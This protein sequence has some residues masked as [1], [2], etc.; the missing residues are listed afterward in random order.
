MIPCK[1]SLHLG[2]RGYQRSQTVDNVPLTDLVVGQPG[3]QGSYEQ[4]VNLVNDCYNP[5]IFGDYGVDMF[6]REILANF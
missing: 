3:Q 1:S 6:M 4:A 5:D 2:L